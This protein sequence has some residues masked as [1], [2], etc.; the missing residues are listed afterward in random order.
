MHAR[1]RP[2]II[3]I[4]V[5][6]DLEMRSTCRDT[7][8]DLA[9]SD[10]SEPGH[11][12]LE[13]G[14]RIPVVRGKHDYL[15]TINDYSSLRRSKVKANRYLSTLWPANIAFKDLTLVVDSRSVA[16]HY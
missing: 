11:Q 10:S 5:Q 8:S 16:P 12:G 1:P 7:K 6:I 14:H 15:R 2:L 13:L 4:D 3:Q 9:D